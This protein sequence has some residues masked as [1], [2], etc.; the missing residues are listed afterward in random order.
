MIGN[1]RM[2]FI[3]I[4]P[5]VLWAAVF[6]ITPLF[7]ILAYGFT[8]DNWG[9][10][11]DNIL[12][13]TKHGYFSS[14]MIS[15]ILA[16]VCTGIC[17]LI[18]YPVCLFLADMDTDISWF[19]LLLFIMPMWINSFLTMM[20]WQSILEKSGII[21]N[22]LQFLGLSKCRLINTQGAIVLGMVYVYLPYMILPIYTSLVKID[23]SLKDAASDLG[24]DPINVFVHVTLPLSL[25][26]I[27]SGITMVFIPALTTFV[28][29]AML[30]GGKVMLIGNII[31]QLFTSGYD[32]HLGSGLSIVLLIFI[33]LN[34]LMQHA[35]NRS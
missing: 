7:I 21:N 3:C 31:D 23:P 35:V 15:I 14:L 29:I 17:L 4:A 26:G 11:L 5:F 6:V 19:M 25:P 2:N 12:T 27:M 34:M 13:I 18:A 20:A 16:L 24:A 9:F 32:W 28:I 8:D 22:F 1:K 33:M 10:T 30:G